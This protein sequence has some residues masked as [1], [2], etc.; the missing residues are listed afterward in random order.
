MKL[1]PDD[2]P[3][4]SLSIGPG[5]GRC[6][7]ISS[8]FAKRFTEGIEKLTGSMPGDRRKNVGGYRIGRINHPYPGVRA[9]E[10]PKLTG[11]PPVPGF[12]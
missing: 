7:K 1:Q 3:R 2:G 9:A 4:L 5:F 8:K 6:S 12:F 10:L 11:R